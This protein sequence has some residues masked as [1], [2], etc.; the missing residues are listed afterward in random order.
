[1][2]VIRDFDLVFKKHNSKNK[3]T[4][5]PDF[6]IP[7][8][9]LNIDDKLTYVQKYIMEK[10]NLDHIKYYEVLT[11]CLTRDENRKHFRVTNETSKLKFIHVNE[12][13]SNRLFTDSYSSTMIH[14]YIKNNFNQLNDEEIRPDMNDLLF[15]NIGSRYTTDVEHMYSTF[16]RILA[17][18]IDESLEEALD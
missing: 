17:D 18:S 2:N 3:I 15:Q 11:R 14:G 1:M 6:L 12:I 10:L 7:D 16:N 8:S 13:V 9:I 4:N 5:K